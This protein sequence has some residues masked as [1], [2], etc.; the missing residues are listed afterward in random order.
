VC[1]EPFMR[2]R[3][4]LVQRRDHAIGEAIRRHSAIAGA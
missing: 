3:E 1:F 2:M 4:M